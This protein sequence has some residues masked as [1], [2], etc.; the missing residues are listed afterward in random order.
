MGEG[1][2]TSAELIS[3]KLKITQLDTFM[4]HLFKRKHKF[5]KR[6]LMQG[7]TCG[8][9]VHWSNHALFNKMGLHDPDKMFFFI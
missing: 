7:T 4:N 2:Y 8:L 3:P 1:V 6:A 5:R 9:H